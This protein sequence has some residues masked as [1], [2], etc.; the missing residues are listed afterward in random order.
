MSK[1]LILVGCGDFGREL[2]NWADD[3]AASGMGQ[4]F[5]GFLDNNPSALDKYSYKLEYLGSVDDFSP[6]NEHLFVIGIANPEA[7]RIVVEKLK[8]KGATFSKLIHPSA[9]IARTAT[10]GEGVVICPHAL[11]SADANLGNFVAVN[12]LSSIGHDAHIGDFSTLSAHVDITGFAH[13]GKCVFFGTGAKVLPKVKIGDGARIGAGT[14]IMR[15][16]SEG[17]VMYVLPAK[18][19]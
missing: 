15:S 14:T 10:L 5:S 18:K 6:K 17:A 1:R 16:V 12:G 4:S 8:S 3:A 13:I 9:V 7:K 2:I 11:V 19:L